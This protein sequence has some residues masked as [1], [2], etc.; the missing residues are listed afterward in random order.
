MTRRKKSR[1]PG[2]LAPSKKPKDPNSAPA[3]AQGKKKGKGHKPGQRHNTLSSKHPAK[4]TQSIQQDPRKG[5][6]RKIPLVAIAEPKLP[7]QLTAAEEL[8]QLEQDH[9][10]QSLVVRF[11]QGED[12]TEAE[13][14]YLDEK[15]DRYE[16]LAEQL[17]I[18]LEDDDDWDDEEY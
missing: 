8:K 4:D 10:L 6:Q 7:T 1:K 2:P 11:E 16:Q 9:K 3:A 15:S 17:G 12:L 5:S 14:R 18:D 13:Q